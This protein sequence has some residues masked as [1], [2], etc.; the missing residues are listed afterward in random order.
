MTWNTELF[1]YSHALPQDASPLVFSEA[2][3]GWATIDS[4]RD[5]GRFD[6]WVTLVFT[7]LVDSE[8][9]G[10]STNATLLTDGAVRGS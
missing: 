8:T 5:R 3:Q 7:A 4:R 6:G 9:S 10:I 1:A 2:D